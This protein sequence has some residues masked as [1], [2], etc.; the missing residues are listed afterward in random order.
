M[1]AWKV[2]LEAKGRNPG[3]VEE[4]EPPPKPEPPPKLKSKA[5]KAEKEQHAL[6]SENYERELEAW[7]KREKEIAENTGGVIVQIQNG[8]GVKQE[9]SRVSFIRREGICKNPGVGFTQQLDIEVEKAEKAVE[10]ANRL[11]EG[12]GVNQ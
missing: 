1:S 9:V 8:S 6:D 3:T 12:S 11:F 5:R 2:V 10:V 4:T 7:E